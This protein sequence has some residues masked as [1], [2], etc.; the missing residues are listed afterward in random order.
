[1]KIII[2]PSKAKGRVHA[3]A[4]KSLGHRYLVGASLAHGKSVIHNLGNWSDDLKATYFAFEDYIKLDDQI[5]ILGRRPLKKKI[6]CRESASS[7]RLLLPLSLIDGKTHEFFAHKKLLQRPMEVYEKLAQEKNFS[8]TKSI[9]KIR[10]QGPLR[11]GNFRIPSHISSQFASGLLFSLPLVEGDSF[12][13]LI[14]PV[15]SFPYIEM[16]LA[17]LKEFHIKI[18]EITK[19]KY[20]IPG[21]QIYQAGNFFLEGDYSNAAFLDAL[22]LL[23][24]KVEVLSLHPSSKQGDRIYKD[25]FKRLQMEEMGEYDL[26]NCPDLGPI[27]FALAGVLQGGVFFHIQR[28]EIKESNRILAMQEEL[29]KFGIHIQRSKEDQVIIKKQDIRP[30]K[31]VLLGHGDHRIIM[32]LS[33]LASLTGGVIDGFEKVSKSYPSFFDDLKSLGIDL[34]RYNDGS[35]CFK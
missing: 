24:G 20:F 6:F 30:P 35:P 23:G 21:D 8:Y 15:E 32:A 13:E 17:V 34:E 29:K 28:L 25:Y 26:K 11:S 10:V 5:V 1:M 16:T 9:D 31:E 27:L 4:S 7:L 2:H 14:E 12:L 3:P 18:E 33:V 19:Y 22:N